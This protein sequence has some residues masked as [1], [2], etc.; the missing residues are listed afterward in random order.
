MATQSSPKRRPIPHHK[1][2]QAASRPGN[3]GLARRFG[4]RLLLPVGG[5]QPALAAA[6]AGAVPGSPVDAVVREFPAASTG[7]S[8]ADLTILAEE[9]AEDW[10]QYLVHLR[11]HGD[12]HGSV[13][14]SLHALIDELDR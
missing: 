8:R 6:G 5:L 1:R 13:P 3:F 2:D 12:E 9:A 7:W 4:D 10:F 11:R 14:E